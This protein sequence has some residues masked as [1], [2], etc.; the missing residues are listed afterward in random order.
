MSSS[1]SPSSGQEDEPALSLPSRPAGQ[2][3]NLAPKPPESLS[4]IA[5][6][7]PVARASSSI[8]SLRQNPRVCRFCGRLRCT[9]ATHRAYWDRNLS[10][11]ADPASLEASMN[12]LRNTPYVE[13]Y[14]YAHYRVYIDRDIAA[15]RLD[16]FLEL[17]I[18]ERPN[19]NELH[20]LFFDCSSTKHSTQ[21][22]DS[23]H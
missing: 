5:R 16:P 3:R 17:P 11:A 8:P 19:I 21:L 15:S 12:R 1:R 22:P 14:S 6:R 18:S 13:S 9:L 7:S 10:G 23:H 4:R 2:F 20:S